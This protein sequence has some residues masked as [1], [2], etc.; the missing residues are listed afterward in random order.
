MPP[1]SGVPVPGANAGSSTSTS[2]VRNAGPVADD[3]QRPLERRGDALAPHL[4]HRDRRDAVALLPRELLGAR[5]VAAQAHLG[6]AAGIDVARLDEPEHRRAV[7]ELDA[8]HVTAR[9]GVGVEVEQAQRAVP[10][11]AR[12]HVG[13]GDRVVAAEHDRDRARR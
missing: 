12:A 10:L 4:V 13:L 6:V 5:P 1:G 11:R 2:T 3:R 7:R 9:V 8:V